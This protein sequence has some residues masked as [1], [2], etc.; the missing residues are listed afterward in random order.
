MNT[1]PNIP[2]LAKRLLFFSGGTALRTTTQALVRNGHD[3]IH[4][5]T[6]FDSGG[7]SAAIRKEFAMP[8][9]GDIRNRL[10]ALAD[11]SG[12]PA[13]F[14]LFAH[15][16]PKDSDRAGLRLELN[17]LT[18]G[19]HP[20]ALPVPDPARGTIL[21]LLRLFRERMPEDFDLRGASIGNLVLTAGYLTGGRRL[22]PAI[23]IFSRLVRARGT[24]RPTVDQDLHLAVRLENGRIVTGQHNITGK[25][26]APLTSPVRDIWL[27]P[28][29][30]N[31]A[32]MQAVIPDEIRRDIAEADLICYPMGSFYSSIVAN[33]LPD[34]V[35]RA[36]AANACPKIFVPGTGLDPE[37]TG[38]DVAGQAL[39]LRRYLEASG[40]PTGSTVL[41]AI[42][43]DTENGHYPGGVDTT[44][45]KNLGIEILDRPLVTT[46]SAPA[47]DGERLSTILL[48]LA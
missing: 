27:T 34:G 42:L 22:A 43:L 39:L 40:A 6:P 15:R 25:E 45:I 11:P 14:A 1:T 46:A 17:R 3:S 41:D 4:L 5:I 16:L 48:S 33:L 9:V 28:A 26:T 10:M 18:D 8:A 12:D 13:I 31:A 21:D 30:D 7:S 35:G 20:L 23:E 37:A 36:V 2:T 24:V 19:T 47:L 44:K 38:L 29:P 32:P